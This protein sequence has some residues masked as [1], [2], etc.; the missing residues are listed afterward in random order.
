VTSIHKVLKLYCPTFY[1]KLNCSFSFQVFNA[2][3]E[4]FSVVY[5][6]IQINMDARS[7]TAN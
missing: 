6:D 4:D 2:D 5:T 3:V 1:L 7:I